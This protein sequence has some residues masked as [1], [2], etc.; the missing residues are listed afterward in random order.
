[1]AILGTSMHSLLQLLTEQSVG[2][3]VLMMSVVIALGL[4]LSQIRV[5]GI[6]PG[7]A[8]VLFVGLFFA[9]AGAAV[10]PELLE[11]I[12][13]FGLIL[14]VYSVGLQVGPGFFSSF[15]R[16]GLPLNLLA[17]G[18]VLMSVALVAAGAALGFLDPAAALGVYSGASTNTPSLAA[19]QQTMK[20]IGT[21]ST[22]QL[23]LTPLAYAVAYPFGVFGTILAMSIARRLFRINL[24]EEVLALEAENKHPAVST[25]NIL[26][27]NPN[28]EGLSIRQIPG[29]S[30]LT[31]NVTRVMSAGIV[32]VAS[33]DTVIHIGDTLLAV[34]PSEAL[35]DLCLIVGREADVDLKEI[36]ADITTGWLVATHRSVFG[37]T[38][39]ELDLAG[40][41]EVK[42]SRIVRA[43]VE[44]AAIPG[45]RL[46]W[47]DR[48]LV[49]GPPP[50]I[51]RVAQRV[52]N[53]L[54]SLQEPEV[55][56]VFAGVAL[57]VFL[58]SVPFAIPGLSSPVKLGLAGGPLVVSILLSRL[59]RLGPLNWYLPASANAML[60]DF[61][62]ALFLAA[63]G[64]KSGGTFFNVI[65]EG[66]GLR[67]MLVGMGVT[68]IPLLS[69]L[70]VGR[71]ILNLNY[72]VLCGV[73]SGAM[74]APGALAFAR[75]TCQSEAPSVSYATVYPLTMLAR[76]VTAQILA[77]LLM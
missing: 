26:A 69:A 63:V 58:G 45:L 13:D 54:K 2:H 66:D 10:S 59:G 72:A 48:L 8:M 36:S 17:L 39:E 43:G 57:G 23:G 27:A 68:T 12:R 49:V 41:S 3:A 47:G 38:L 4:S 33:P 53:S 6:Q 21:L 11:F 22:E 28:L 31:I 24:Q 61:G 9:Q 76:I 32:R 51:S 5:F 34:G 20:S 62:I 16:S 44:F 56:P 60:R 65:R 42:V 55:A 1:M 18:M 25:L 64:L 19:I 73:L 30:G 75:T 35:R 74:T 15:R 50:G 52:G 40:H 71:K 46:Q 70:V 7:I 14:F 67:W 77:I 29:F 37:K